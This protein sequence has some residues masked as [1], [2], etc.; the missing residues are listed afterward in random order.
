MTTDPETLKRLAE[1]LASR[2]RSPL[3]RWLRA[4]RESFAAVLA[5]H[6]TDWKAIAAVLAAAGV[7]DEHGRAPNAGAVRMA[8]LRLAGPRGR[9]P[10]VKPPP[11]DVVFLTDPAPAQPL[12]GA[13]RAASAADDA[14]EA[15]RRKLAERSGI[16]RG[17]GT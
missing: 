17:G 2:S 15:I 11:R 5:E 9:Q 13:A 16:V 3:V 1:A 10:K 4:N 8:W 6:G 12:G 14:T 7:T